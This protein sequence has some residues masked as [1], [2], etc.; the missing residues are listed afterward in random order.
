[1]VT[2]TPL[3]DV[4]QGGL[5][6]IF[7]SCEDLIDWN[8]SPDVDR[9]RRAPTRGPT[10]ANRPATVIDEEQFECYRCLG[11]HIARNVFGGPARELAEDLRNE[12]RVAKELP[13][14]EYVPKLFAAVQQRW[15]EAPEARARSTRRPMALVRNPPR[16]LQ[17]QRP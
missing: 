4:D 16:S 9:V 12:K 13:H 8:E 17:D 7:R 5:P 3:R 1:M 6:G 15:S 2:V 11:D 10:S 14:Q